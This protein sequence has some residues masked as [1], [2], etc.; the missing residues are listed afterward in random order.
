MINTLLSPLSIL[1]TVQVNVQVTQNWM[2]IF[3]LL[4]FVCH[5][6]I[7]LDSSS[8]F[9]IWSSS[10]ETRDYNCKQLA[11]KLVLVILILVQFLSLKIMHKLNIRQNLPW[12]LSHYFHSPSSV[13]FPLSYLI[14]YFRFLVWTLVY[15][16]S[17]SGTW[18]NGGNKWG[19]L[20]SHA[21]A[22][23]IQ[24]IR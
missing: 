6:N 22:N 12:F 18:E 15:C 17:S 14:A 7:L 24:S 4:L 23:L 13:R 5:F 21:V 1:V 19:R 8:Y 9:F 2:G 3:F 20:K 16:A 11:C 10:T